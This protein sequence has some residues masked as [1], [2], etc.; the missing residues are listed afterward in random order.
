M[1]RGQRRD[2]PAHAMAGDDDTAGI[3]AE[4]ARVGGITEEGEDGVG[5]LEIVGE[6][7]FTG[8]AP[9]PAIVDGD[10]VPSI[11]SHGLCDVEVLLVA[12]QAVKEDEGRVRAGARCEV[13]D[14]VDLYTARRDVQ[15]LHARRMRTVAR[16]VDVD[17]ARDLL[18][19]E[20]RRR[21]GGSGG[22]DQ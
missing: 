18:R 22:D 1:R 8:T 13:G 3:D 17:G 9:R 6:A 10:R 11:A 12:R 21:D 16:W 14:A 5:V 15:D 2:P 4:A 20:G 7:E 19:R